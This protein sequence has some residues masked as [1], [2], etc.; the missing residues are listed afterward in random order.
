[1]C[2]CACV[3]V[4][5]RNKPQWFLIIHKQHGTELPKWIYPYERKCTA[6]KGSSDYSAFSSRGIPGVQRNNNNEFIKKYWIYL[7]R[8]IMWVLHI[9]RMQLLSGFFWE[10]S[11]PTYFPQTPET[12]KSK[13]HSKIFLIISKW[14]KHSSQPRYGILMDRIKCKCFLAL[15]HLAQHC[16]KVRLTI[17][18]R[19]HWRNGRQ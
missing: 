19:S 17:H 10:H 6:I 9:G 18:Q 15:P 3:A 1:M 7:K 13:R 14:G 4:V 11:V 16:E 2:Q 8:V 12:W 5:V